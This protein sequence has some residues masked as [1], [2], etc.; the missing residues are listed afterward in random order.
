MRAELPSTRG[1]GTR[2]SGDATRADDRL[3]IVTD[4]HRPGATVIETPRL[5]LREL[6][7]ADLEALA[8]LYVPMPT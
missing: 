1:T 2:A 8:A 4:A 5:V 3:R 6:V 7:P